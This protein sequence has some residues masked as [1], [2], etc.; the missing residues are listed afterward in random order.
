MNLL[1]VERRGASGKIR[2]FV[3][4]VT[5]TLRKNVHL[6]F[7]DN[8]AAIGE[9]SRSPVSIRPKATKR[10]KKQAGVSTQ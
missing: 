2:T 8:A 9:V 1:H 5:E 4:F 3:E 6:R 10:A 7:A